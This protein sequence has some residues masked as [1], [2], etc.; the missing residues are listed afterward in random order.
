MLLRFFLILFVIFAFI[1]SVLFYWQLTANDIELLLTKEKVFGVRLALLDDEKDDSLEF[2]IQAIVFPEYKRVLL[3]FLNTDSYY[4]DDLIRKLS[5]SSADLFHNYTAISSN[6]Y[7]HIRCKDA[8]RLIDLLEGVVLFTEKDVFLEKAKYQYPQGIHHYSGEQ[9]LEY[10][11]LKRQPEKR[12]S[13]KESS[14]VD[15]LFRQESMLLNLFWQRK[16]MAEHVSNDEMKN[17]IISLISTSLTNEE[18][19]SLLAYL[20]GEDIH[21]STLEIPL[22]LAAKQGKKITRVKESKVNLFQNYLAK[23]KI[24]WAKPKDDYAVQI[25]NGT[26]VQGLARRA[27]YS[28]Q[29]LGPRIFD[30]DNYEPK[31]LIHTLILVRLGD[32]LPAMRLMHLTNMKSSRVI[33]ARQASDVDLSLLLGTDFNAKKLV[34][35]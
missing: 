9:V 23:A 10:I 1:L 26:Q 15:R 18:L 35:K 16:A 25:L 32:T 2:L 31:P 20:L 7:I 30:T 4:G 28:L 33:F 21:L 6:D 13:Q 22:E 34:L 24:G 11:L 19:D 14:H 12:Q 27:K 8:K 17:F 3:Y 5:P 29:N